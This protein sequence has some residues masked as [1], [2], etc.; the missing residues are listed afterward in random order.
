MT[1]FATQLKEQF[2]A[3]LKILD[4]KIVS[5]DT[6]IEK[7]T[8]IINEAYAAIKTV[9]TECAEVVSVMHDF[10]TNVFDTA[11]DGDNTV[12]TAQVVMDDCYT[13]YEDGYIQDEDL[14]A[15]LAATVGEEDEDEIV[16][17]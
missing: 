15:E 16:A 8:G 6:E 14:D 3:I 2:D 4:D 17:E 13:L 10:A 1:E 11:T 7:Q 12:D 5:Y 9:K